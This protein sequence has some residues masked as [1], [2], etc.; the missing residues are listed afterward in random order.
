MKKQINNSFWLARNS[1]GNLTLFNTKPYKRKYVINE[2][3]PKHR[4]EIEGWSTKD[5]EKYGIGFLC[6]D[7]NLYPEITLENSP[8]K[9][10][11]KIV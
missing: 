9:V 7:K 4:V 2:E 11:F 5:Y 1:E 3:F 10:I 8:K 6:V